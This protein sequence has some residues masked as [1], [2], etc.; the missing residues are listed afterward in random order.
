MSDCAS[1]WVSFL[2]T[3]ARSSKRGR[4]TRNKYVSQTA[5]SSERGLSKAAPP[6]DAACGLSSFPYSKDGIPSLN[7]KHRV[8]M[9]YVNTVP[10]GCH[11]L[12]MPAGEP[13]RLAVGSM[14]GH[15]KVNNSWSL[16]CIKENLTQTA[17]YIAQKVNFFRFVVEAVIPRILLVYS[18]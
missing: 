10:K 2:L 13:P 16:L 1:P 11:S 5:R 8:R 3:E 4:H 14:S 18:T 12:A 7:L 9:V 6:W 17:S 15:A